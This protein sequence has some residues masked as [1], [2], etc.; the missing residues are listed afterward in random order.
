MF[1]PFLSFF[2]QLC[3]NNEAFITIKGSFVGFSRFFYV[4]FLFFTSHTLASSLINF[5]GRNKNKRNRNIMQSSIII[6]EC[7]KIR[8]QKKVAIT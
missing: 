5:R 3:I 2:L 7:V 6:L 1:F 4:L 8:W